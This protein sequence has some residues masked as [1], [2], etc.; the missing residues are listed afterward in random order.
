MRPVLCFFLCGLSFKSIAAPADTVKLYFDLG[1]AK[2]TPKS[3]H[4]MDSLV[5]YEKLIPGKKLGIIGYADFLGSEESNVS[6]SENRAKNVQEYLVSLGIKA[7]DI[8]TVI[9]KG[10]VRRDGMTDKSGFPTDRRVDIIPGG[11]KEPPKP[12][13]VK[14]AVIPPPIIDISKVKKNEAIKLENMFFEPGSHKMRAESR[15]TLKKLLAVMK[16]N[17]TLVIQIEGHIC[18]LD[19][20]NTEGYDYDTQEYK[21]SENRAKA[22]YD[23]LED[24]GIDEERMRYKG[25]GKKKPLVDPEETEE[26]QNK[27]RRVE[28]R[29]LKK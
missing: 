16:D 20:H 25:F 24:N 3:Q 7:S 5:Y 17:P 18:C 14:P 10:E 23:Y 8:Q 6:L 29:I 9:G 28:I 26:D 19:P 13:A 15:P 4:V 21:L 11:F 22:V 2:L 27:N 12:V 1:I